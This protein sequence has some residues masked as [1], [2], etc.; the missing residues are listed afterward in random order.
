TA[1]GE[2]RVSMTFQPNTNNIYFI[3]TR[4]DQQN[5]IYRRVY[6]WNPDTGNWGALSASTTITSGVNYNEFSAA[7]APY[8]NS[9]VFAFVLSTGYTQVRYFT[10][11]NTQVDISPPSASMRYPTVTC[12]A[13]RIYILHVNS[14][15]T[16]YRYYDG[17]WSADYLYYSGTDY[18][19]PNSLYRPSASSVDFVWLN[20]T[21]I[22][23]YGSI[24]PTGLTKTEGPNYD[25]A[26]GNPYGS[27]GGSLFSYIDDGHFDYSFHR[28]IVTYFTNFTSPS[29]WD[30]AKASFAWQFNLTPTQKYNYGNYSHVKLDSVALV[31][32][33]SDGNDLAV[34]YLDDNYGN[35]WVG[36]SV[37][38]LYRTNI[39]VNYPMQQNTEY[40]LKVVFNIS[41]SDPSDLSHITTRID[42]VGISFTRYSALLNVEFSGTSD[43]YEWSKI[44]LNITSNV[45]R[46]P[47]ECVVRVYNFDLGR[48]PV[49]GEQGYFNFTYQNLSEENR[50]L[51]I[52]SG[53]NSF[54]DASGSWNISISLA[55]GSNELKFGLNM[56]N[57]IPMVNVH[58]VSVEFEGTS[59][60]L[61]WISLL[62][63]STQAFSVPSVQ[64]TIQ[65]YNYTAGSY[66][67]SG[68]GYLSYTSS[69]SPFSFESFSQSSTERPGD[70]KDAS[71][72]WKI[73][74]SA[75]KVGRQFYM[76]SDYMLYSP[77]LVS[78]QQIDAYFVFQ[79]VVVGT[80]FN[81]T[82]NITSLFN[83][84][85][86]NVT[87]Q[88]WDYSTSSWSTVYSIN[89]I[90]G[91]A[92]TPEIASIT[93]TSDFSKY[94]SSGESRL[95]IY[96]FKDEQSP[97][98]FNADQIKLDVW[99]L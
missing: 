92:N 14:S 95:R 69:N 75:T 80:I 65:L 13:E 82:Y 38:Y 39:S 47:T 26:N 94:V 50:V 30:E 57:F 46:V 76:L 55:C 40:Q 74:I 98:D 61:E 7:P 70:F 19:L 25:P 11:E 72:N 16:Y 81:M 2:T 6:R 10:S 54:R 28:F 78:Q 93:V 37:G 79:N 29:S 85:S 17:S 32:A 24:F 22:I 5:I 27:G 31:L 9:V 73:L 12:I 62:W 21:E 45:T 87:F 8:N 60:T 83:M 91:P 18:S 4:A 51:E 53:A 96:A 88:L 59:D 77:T 23:L 58:S 43:T 89:Y 15:G 42:D 1:T 90:S 52:A 86:V 64:V 63:N 49:F 3:F 68:F 20:R 34:L 48:Y 84:T 56:L 67:S 35:G 71:G 66:Q 99:A 36:V 33:D 97:F 44:L 41:C